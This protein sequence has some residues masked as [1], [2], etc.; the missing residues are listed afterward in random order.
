[1][2]GKNQRQVPE[3]KIKSVKELASL[4]NTK[5]TVLFASIKNLPASQYQ[6]I[7]KKLR[8]KSVIKVPKKS[9]LFRAID[10]SKNEK[11]KEL[12]ECFENSVAVLFSDL[13]SYEL[14]GELLKNK[15]PAKAKPGQE[16]PEDIEIPAGPT[17]LPPGPAISELGAVGLQVQIEK[18]KITIKEPKVIVKAGEKISE[19]A[20]DVMNKLNIKPFSIGFIPLCAFD[21]EK[22]KLYLNIKIN[23][24]E[25]VEEL[26]S[27]YGKALAFSVEVGY[28]NNDTVKFLLG[29]A[30]MHGK[31]L[32]KLIKTKP[33]EKEAEEKTE[34]KKEAAEAETEEE[35]ETQIPTEEKTEEAEIKE[36]SEETSEEG[37]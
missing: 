23:P 32:E 15:S 33:E 22:E 16:A 35:K 12:K 10:E 13:D 11:A 18:G 37:K 26:K 9:I 2:P 34:E 7:K 4:I 30:G 31:A 1:M 29:K 5:K 24:K 6:E 19:S 27:L 28:I 17:D 3:I 8:G 25:A 20:A 36:A 21:K 14:A